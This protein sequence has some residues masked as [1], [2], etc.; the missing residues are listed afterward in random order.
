MFGEFKIE[1]FD[2]NTTNIITFLHKMSMKENWR[3][4]WN[5]NCVNFPEFAGGVWSFPSEILE[6]HYYKFSTISKHKLPLT[7]I[8]H[9]Q[10]GRMAMYMSW[11]AAQ[12]GN[13]NTKQQQ[14]YV[15]LTGRES[16]GGVCVGGGGCEGGWGNA[17]SN[18]AVPFELSQSKDFQR[19]L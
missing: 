12:D 15:G 13:K 2:Y 8:S 11:L 17:D 4:N 10:N 18:A 7:V 3:S 19:A 14:I 9:H 5:E 16:V 6:Y 1:T